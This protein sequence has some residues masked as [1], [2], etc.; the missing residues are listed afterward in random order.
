[1]MYELLGIKVLY[2]NIFPPFLLLLRTVLSF[3]KSSRSKACA[4]F[5]ELLQ[6]Y[7]YFPDFHISEDSKIMSLAGKSVSFAFSVWLRSSACET[8]AHP[9]AE[10]FLFYRFKWCYREHVGLC[11]WEF[12]SQPIPS[13]K[14][15]HCPLSKFKQ[16]WEW[17]NSS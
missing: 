3:I 2:M 17:T 11:K 16:Q 6:N 12:L 9:A 13:S 15:W 1:M 4:K 14:Q 7:K 8:S 5:L 10:Y